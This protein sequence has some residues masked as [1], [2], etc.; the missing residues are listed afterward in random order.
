VALGVGLTGVRGQNAAPKEDKPAA[1]SQ[2]LSNWSRNYRDTLVLDK[3]FAEHFTG[4]A[5]EALAAFCEELA[6]AGV[7]IPPAATI[8]LRPD[9]SALV[10]DYPERLITEKS[11]GL[12]DYLTQ[13]G[14]WSKVNVAAAQARIA[15]IERAFAPLREEVETQRKRVDAAYAEM[16]Q[17]RERAN[18]IDPDPE[19]FGSNVTVANAQTRTLE[20]ETQ[21]QRLRV[22][23]LQAQ[24]DRIRALR[25]E[26]LDVAM[27]IVEVQ[28]PSVVQPVIEAFRIACGDESKL[29][30]DGVRPD[31]PRRKAL[32]E[33]TAALKRTLEE[34]L[35]SLK[36][37]QETLLEIQKKN[38]ANLEE[39]LAVARRLSID[40]KKEMF[41]YIEAKSRYLQAK[42]IFDAA[43]TKY[44]TELLDAGTDR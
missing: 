3:S 37:N 21:D 36:K 31:D 28:N 19:S 33:K 44:S 22:T 26:E 23:T 8:E 32:G 29:I 14:W 43:Q 34:A 13:K 41:A 30:E 17:I 10:I 39:G 15:A 5:E 12:T 35:A 40:A 2:T 38:L 9:K 16:S 18:V 25:P 6:A 1:A 24:C 20:K 27:A 7:A 11:W 42:R 4:T